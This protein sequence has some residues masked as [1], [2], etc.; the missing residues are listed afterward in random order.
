MSVEFTAE[1]K[2]RIHHFTEMAKLI[3]AFKEDFGNEAYKTVIK[4]KGEQAFNEWKEIAANRDT[5]TIHDLIELLWKPLE[6]EGFEYEVTE[7][8]PGIHVNCTKCS[9][10]ELAKYCGITEELF[11]LCCETD[12]Y[13]TEGF[14]SN[15]GFKRTKTLMQGH[16]CCDNFYYYKEN[17]K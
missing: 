15:I 14:N 7:T 1:Q 11:Y 3:R 2:F 12:P 6:N 4:H 5:N 8:E 16:E 9:L 10:Y 13:I 17:D